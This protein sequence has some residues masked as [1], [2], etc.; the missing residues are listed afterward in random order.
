[1]A[2]RAGPPEMGTID[3]RL[4]HFAA[5]KDDYDLVFVGSS[6]VERGVVPP[7]FDAE[8]AARGHVVRSFNF[9]AAGMEAHEANAL[10]RRLIALEPARLA[11]VVVELDTWDPGLEESNRFK[12]RAVFWHDP[13]ETWSALRST[14]SLEAS[15]AARADLAA[16]HVLH[17]AARSLALGRGPDAVR[18]I[19]RGEESPAD[20]DLAQWRGFKPYTES[21]YRF[22]PLRRRFLDRPDDYRQAVRRLERDAGVAP[23]P[24]TVAAVREQVAMIRAAGLGPVHLVPPSPRAVPRVAEHV[25]ALLAFNRPGEYAELFAIERRFDREHLTQEGAEH[26]SRL[27]AARFAT[28]VLGAKAHRVAA[29]GG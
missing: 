9:G 12:R 24:A 6:R 21:S 29:M 4:R 25:P 3:D 19:S 2:W 13:A 28:E 27:L 22:N 20:P 18:S 7:V 14:A 23:S 10:V 8:L 26:F 5:H 17:F 1:M 11:W 16:T 15:L